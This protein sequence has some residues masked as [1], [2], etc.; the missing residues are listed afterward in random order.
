[1]IGLLPW[2]EVRERVFQNSG[3]IRSEWEKAL[4][5]ARVRHR[6]EVREFRGINRLRAAYHRKRGRRW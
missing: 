3:R 2:G 5:R 6:S 4:G 1:M